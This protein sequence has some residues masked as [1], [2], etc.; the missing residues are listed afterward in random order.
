MAANSTGGAS[1]FAAFEIAT[2][3]GASMPNSEKA[4]RR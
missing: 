3:A 2:T 4:P 1:S